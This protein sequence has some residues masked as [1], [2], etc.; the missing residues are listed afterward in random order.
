MKYGANARAQM[1]KVSH[2]NF[3]EDHCM[4]K[5]LILMTLELPYKHC[6]PFTIIVTHCIPMLMMKQLQL[7][8]RNRVRRAMAIQLIIN[9]EL[10][11]LK[12]KIPCKVPLLLKSLPSW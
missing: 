10:G 2:S 6:M 9:K 11:L 3:M 5:R 4:L 7:L 1:L 12:M 8:P